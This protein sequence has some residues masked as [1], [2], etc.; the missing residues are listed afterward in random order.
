MIN[1][2]GRQRQ[3]AREQQPDYGDN[4]ISFK[5]KVELKTEK[6]TSIFIIQ[7]LHKMLMK[8]ICLMLI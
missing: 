1:V 2:F 3:R 8:F 4:P 6:Y 7:T 5:K